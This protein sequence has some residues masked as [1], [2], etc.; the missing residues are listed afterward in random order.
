MA[1]FSQQRVQVLSEQVRHLARLLNRPGQF[2]GARQRIL[3]AIANEG[4]LAVPSLAR[5]I[6]TSRQ[7]VQ[8]LI[9]RLAQDGCIEPCDNPAHKRS[10]LYRLTP[11]GAEALTKARQAETRILERLALPAEQIEMA[12]EVLKRIGQDLGAA[13][14][15]QPQTNQ[16]L[17]K[18]RKA[19]IPTVPSEEIDEHELPVNLL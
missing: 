17:R 15:G 9:D 4:A 3:L 14:S 5:T 19:S 2:R 13:N 11:T 12:I 10:P 8:L 6:G 1:A 18:P 16:P 7:N